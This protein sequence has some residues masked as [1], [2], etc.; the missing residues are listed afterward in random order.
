MNLVK[1]CYKVIPNILR[2]TGKVKNPW[3]NVD[4]H[5]GVL[6]NHYGIKEYDYYTVVFAVSRSIGCMSNLILSRALGLPIERPSSITF[7][8]IEKK[9]ENK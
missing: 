4:A 2:G 3:P 8:W 6:L 7:D 9:F 5:S 1:K